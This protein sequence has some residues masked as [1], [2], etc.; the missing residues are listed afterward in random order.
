MQSPR[1]LRLLD[2]DTL[3]VEV[4]LFLLYLGEGLSLSELDRLLVL[5]II[6]YSK[7]FCQ[8]EV[9]QRLHVEEV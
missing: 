5:S 3:E 6:C 1:V 2:L 7:V 9:T 8:Q 4:D